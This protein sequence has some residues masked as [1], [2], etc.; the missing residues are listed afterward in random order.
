MYRDLAAS[1]GRKESEYAL[2][3]EEPALATLGFAYEQR[4]RLPGGAYHPALKK[5]E[6]FLDRPLGEALRERERRA[7]LLLELDD[8]VAEAVERLHAQG[9]DSPY[10]K[11]F[12][13]ARV[14]PLRFAPKASKAEPPGFD[15][16]LATMTRRARGL[17]PS[18]IR[19]EDVARAGG[20]AEAEG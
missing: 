6:A 19:R 8:A 11:A 15:E 18:K 1:G 7:A 10:L 20:A 9:L 4:G 16:L 3:F 13:V 2:E 12:V 5:V 17:D 14:N